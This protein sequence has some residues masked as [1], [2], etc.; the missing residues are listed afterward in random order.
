MASDRKESR[1]FRPQQEGSVG[2]CLL[3]CRRGSITAAAAAGPD[4]RVD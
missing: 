3:G 2:Q 4:A 1:E